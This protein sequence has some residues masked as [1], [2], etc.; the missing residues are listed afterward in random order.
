MAY[1]REL[2]SSHFPA[3]GPLFHVT[4]YCQV[5]VLFWFSFR[6]EGRGEGEGGGERRIREEAGGEQDRRRR[7]ERSW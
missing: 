5:M 4:E 6:I 1:L 3:L 2:H 7:G